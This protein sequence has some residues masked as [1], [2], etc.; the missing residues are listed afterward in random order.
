MVLTWWVPLDSLGVVVCKVSSGGSAGGF[1]TGEIR[2]LSVFLLVLWVGCLVWA[3]VGCSPC[4]WVWFS[5][6]G[7]VGVVGLLGKGLAATGL[8]VHP[9]SGL[10]P[11]GYGCRLLV[12]SIA[13]LGTSDKASL[14]MNLYVL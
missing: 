5:G 4:L 13:E 11:D 3:C 12:G 8:P 1:G 9:A 7:L 14:S 10:Q 6:C 2:G